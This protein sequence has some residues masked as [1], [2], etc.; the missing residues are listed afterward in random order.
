VNE[1]EPM[2]PCVSIA[3]HVTVVVPSRNVDPLG[4]EQ[5]AASAMSTVSVAEAV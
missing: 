5:L 2:L 4:G 1:A 3:V